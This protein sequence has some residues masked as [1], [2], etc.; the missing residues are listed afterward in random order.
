MVC[1]AVFN[2]RSLGAQA[3]FDLNSK[4]LPGFLCG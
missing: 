1:G 3:V 4:F 2:S